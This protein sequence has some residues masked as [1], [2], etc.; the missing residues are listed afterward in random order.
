[1]GSWTKKTE[2]CRDSP[3]RN[4]SSLEERRR[5]GGE[6]EKWRGGK[7]QKNWETTGQ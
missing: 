4:A 3:N 6:V 5:G 1:M 7:D 2:I